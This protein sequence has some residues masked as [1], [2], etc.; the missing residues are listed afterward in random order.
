MF[1][2]LQAF[3][4]NP[5]LQTKD[6]NTSK[7][8]TNIMDDKSDTMVEQ[9]SRCRDVD[10][11]SS[12]RV[13]SV[14]RPYGYSISKC[15]YC[16]GTRSIFTTEDEST[17]PEIKSI[18]SPSTSRS[19]KSSASKLSLASK[20]Y[21]VLAD[22]VS[23]ALYEELINMG[24]R[25]S[26]LHLYKPQN[27]S[28]CCPTLTTR[29]LTRDFQ[30]SKSQRRVLKKVEKLF[31]VCPRPKQGKGESVHVGAVPHVMTPNSTPIITSKKQKRDHREQQT[32]NER[33]ST[34]TDTSQ[35][36][37]SLDD[38]GVDRMASLVP[39]S[40]EEQVI[41]AG[42]LRT[43]EQTTSGA[44]QKYLSSSIQNSKDFRWKTSYRLLPPSKRER[45]RSQI[46]AVSSICAQICGQLGTRCSDDSVSREQLVYHVVQV[47]KNTVESSQNTISNIPNGIVISPNDDKISITSIDAHQPS[48]QIVCTIRVNKDKMEGNTDM[49][50]DDENE[51]S[52]EMNGAPSKEHDNLFRAGS[53]GDC[54]KLAQWYEKTTGKR[55]ELE[56]NKQCI[57]IET[58]PSHQSAL[59]P[60]VHKLYAHYQHIVH[61]DPN[62]FS[63]DQKAKTRNGDN[64][65]SQEDDEEP[66]IETDDPSTLDW[67]EAPKYFTSEISAMLTTYT[68]HLES[69][70]RRRAVLSNY[71]SFF[72]FLVE[73]P[74]PVDCHKQNGRQSNDGRDTQN[75]SGPMHDIK[76]DIATSNLPCGLYHQQYRIGG[77]FLIAVGVIDVLPTGLSSV[78]LFYHPNF[79][80]DLVAL[81][82]YAILKEIEFARDVLNVPYYYLGY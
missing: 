42:V 79:S 56:P 49:L 50:I 67:G 65:K 29:L 70:E 14:I 64:Y 46:K 18:S 1:V 75:A 2:N 74:F 59:N 68:Q 10:M 69:K 47:I 15:G 24:W 27:F 48:G 37:S 3:P 71:Y 77:D 32:L 7:S 44:I 34:K 43:L 38:I 53:N 19:T 55:L 6:R 76:T 63:R 16:K 80:Y 36:N 17:P 66:K 45:K 9:M 40:I 31:S 41:A 72:Q 81:G 60:D 12:S 30:P 26:G 39:T 52:S 78:Y 11:T 33:E 73:A 28:S 61:D 8:V 62:P 25:R 21:S 20:S 22:S 13:L 5:V 23:P 82:K 35:Q 51:N 57:T 4:T 58:L 54:S